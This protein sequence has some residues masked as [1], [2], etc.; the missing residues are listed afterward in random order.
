MQ[1]SNAI[2]LTELQCNY[3]LLND[4]TLNS[5]QSNSYIH[6]LK[7][8]NKLPFDKF[9]I[10]YSDDLWDFSLASNL[11]IMKKSLKFNFGL[12]ENS[13]FKD[14][15]KNYVLLSI[16]EN[17]TKIQT[18]HKEFY[19]IKTFLL[20]VENKYHVYNI[21]D[22]S[23]PIVKGYLTMIRDTSSVVQ[24]RRIKTTLKTFFMQ[25]SANFKD[26]ASKGLLNLFE[27][28]DPKAFKAYQYA[29]RSQDIPKDY[30]NQLVSACI[31]IM[32]D[33]TEALHDRGT[34]CLYIILSQTGL[35]IGEILGLR[36]GCIHTTSIFNGE[37]AHYLEYS[38][39]K[40]ENGNN[41]ST[42]ALTY[43]NELT[44]EAYNILIQIY[45]ERRQKFD[46]DYLYMGGKNPSKKSFPFNSETFKHTAFRFFIKLDNMGL[47]EAVNLAPDK[48]PTLHV[49]NPGVPNMVR[50]GKTRP[51]KT[52]SEKVNT[53]TFPD[54]QQFRF[55]CCSVLADKGVPLEYIQRFMSH[56]TSDMVRYHMLPQSSPQ[57]D[58]E[59]SLK[60][61]REVASGKTKILGDNKGLS[62][63]IK[64]FIEENNFKVATDLEE[65]CETLAKK[66]PIRQKTGGVCIKSSQL[67]ECSM[68]A[69]TNEFYCAY[70]VCPNIVHFYYMADVTYRQCK[71]L[72]E[73]ININKERGHMRQ[74][75]KETN[76]LY[77]ITKKRLI[78]ELEDLKAVI[79]RDGFESVYEIHPEV[80]PI[81]ENMDNIEK[82]AITW[83]TKN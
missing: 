57:E 63:S 8:L 9:D 12:M 5:K 75:E 39:W 36:V 3:T 76:M 73:T 80:Q 67:R 45:A 2:Y 28:D 21:E 23:I 53:V 47:L 64:K 82:E 50:N 37:E 51:G 59:F 19:A 30:F 24:L 54:S 61:L 52:L 15:V 26:V 7:A 68:D 29:H 83:S 72:Q 49:F 10:Y 11:N 35:R 69:K 78:P 13:A 40:R 41:T 20:E 81:V 32:N 1:T 66:L 71:E 16:L 46:L 42:S 60:T 44:Y 56:L 4:F 65:I 58:M 74:V 25:Y 79:K 62:E 17:K 43:V 48:Y 31:Q 55:H 33:E 38:T 22:I 34:A 18:I 77:T 70:G 27:Q 14:D 6:A